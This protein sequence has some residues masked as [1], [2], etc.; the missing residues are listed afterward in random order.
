MNKDL[1]ALSAAFTKI[2]RKLGNKEEIKKRTIDNLAYMFDNDYHNIELA[3]DHRIAELV[4]YH[5]KKGDFEAIC[6]RHSSAKLAE[7]MHDYY[8]DGKTIE[9]CGCDWRG[10]YQYMEFDKINDL[11]LLMNL[12]FFFKWLMEENYRSTQPEKM[13][14]V[15][16]FFQDS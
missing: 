12:K 4:K 9:E 11:N 1:K 8:S 10:W 15:I 16:L 3:M 2:T 5:E 6:K 14:G 13:H 7:C